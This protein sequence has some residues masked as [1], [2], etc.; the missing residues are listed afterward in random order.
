L[1]IWFSWPSWVGI[2]DESEFSLRS[3]PSLRRVFMPSSVGMD[4]VSVLSAKFSLVNS[5]SRPNSVGIDP[6]KPSF[7]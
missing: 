2:V 6:V 5:V 3:T 7:L 1:L 4:P